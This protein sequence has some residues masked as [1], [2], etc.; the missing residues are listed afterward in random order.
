MSSP[1][2]FCLTAAQLAGLAQ[3]QRDEAARGLSRFFSPRRVALLKVARSLAL[4]GLLAPAGDDYVLTPAGVAA[5]RLAG[6]LEAA[7]KG[8]DTRAGRQIAQAQG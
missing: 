8:A 7:G 2:A 4:K 5:A 3:I 6:A 1:I